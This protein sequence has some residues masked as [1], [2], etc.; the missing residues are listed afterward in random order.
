MSLHQFLKAFFL[1]PPS[2][3]TPPPPPHH[4]ELQNENESRE[5]QFNHTT[6]HQHINPPLPYRAFFQL[7]SI[8][9]LFEFCLLD[10]SAVRLK[11]TP[12]MEEKTLH[13]EG[14]RSYS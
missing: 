5:T 8:L 11:Y 10:L 6:V 14:C 12:Q 9:F 13:C 2:L 4:A 7:F 3:H 1:A